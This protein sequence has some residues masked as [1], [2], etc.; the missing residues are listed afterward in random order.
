MLI[1]LHN[2][3]KSQYKNIQKQSLQIKQCLLQADEYFQAAENISDAIRPLLLYYGTMSLALCELLFKGDGN[4]SLDSARGKHAHHGLELK[5]DGNPS[6][7]ESLL[8]SA[9]ALSAIPHIRQNEERFGTF[10]LWHRGSREQPFAGKHVIYLEN[11]QQQVTHRCIATP[12]INRFPGMP[13]GGVDLLWCFKNTPGLR[14]ILSDHNINSDLVEGSMSV[15]E[16]QRTGEWFNTVV[17]HPYHEDQL[18]NCLSNIEVD[19]KDYELLTI[20]EMPS[21]IIVRTKFGRNHPTNGS[22]MPMGFQIS[23]DSIMFCSDNK[24]LNEFGVYY[25]GL[26]ILGNYCRYYPDMWMNDVDKCTDL[27]I[28]ATRFMDIAADRLPIIACAE[29]R[30]EYPIERVL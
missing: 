21:G 14:N 13:K 11:G 28:I 17:I 19:A 15:T 12:S 24:I 10:E 16:D 22:R 30:G 4:A 7:T 3:P 1:E 5:I 25:T 29:L 9:S 18:I 8:V 20:V 26:Y 23:T 27:Y 6:E 2:P